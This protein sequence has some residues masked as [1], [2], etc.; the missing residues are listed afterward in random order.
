MR[1][2][3]AAQAVAGGPPPDDWWQKMS[4]NIALTSNSVA[5]YSNAA[6]LSTP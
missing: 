6:A 1:G 3:L 2:A 5:T 4:A